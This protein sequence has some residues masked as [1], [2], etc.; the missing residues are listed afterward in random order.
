[1]YNS[2]FLAKRDH[3]R[4]QISSN[5]SCSLSEITS[6]LL[7]TQFLIFQLYVNRY[8]PETVEHLQNVRRAMGPNAS[9]GAFKALFLTVDAAVAG[10]RELD[11][12]AKGDFTGPSMGGKNEAAGAGVALVGSL[13]L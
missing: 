11:Q 9:S 5:A 2:T 8:R 1:M 4:S 10:K 13:A 6:V 7:P 12:R 3:P